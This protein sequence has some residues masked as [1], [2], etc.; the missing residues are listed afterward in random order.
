MWLGG[1]TLPIGTPDMSATISA[2]FVSDKRA[3]PFAF[4]SRALPL[5]QL[6]LQSEL[7]PDDDERT[8]LLTVHRIFYPPDKESP[9]PIQPTL[10]RKRSPKM[11]S[12]APDPKHVLAEDSHGLQKVRVGEGLVYVDHPC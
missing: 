12:F 7:S 6:T 4:V 5:S 2:H 3:R 8:L 10:K 1:M 9:D 11:E